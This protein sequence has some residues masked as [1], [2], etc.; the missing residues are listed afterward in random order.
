MFS[1]VEF[2]FDHALDLSV[3]K[4]VITVCDSYYF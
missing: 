3:T 1:G 2:R 4:S